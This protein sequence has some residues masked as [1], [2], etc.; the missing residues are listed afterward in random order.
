MDKRIGVIEE[1]E[2]WIELVPDE[3][4][5]EHVEAYTS[6]FEKNKM[7]LKFLY[8]KNCCRACGMGFV[9]KC[10]TVKVPFNIGEFIEGIVI[11][12]DDI[13]E[14]PS[15]YYKNRLG[16]DYICQL[17]KSG[18]FETIYK[19]LKFSKIVHYSERNIERQKSDE[20]APIWL[21]EFARENGAN[22]AYFEF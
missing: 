2:K 16:L 6:L 7:V 1:S 14:Q 15:I 17:E 5:I 12:L 22:V 9:Q 11:C 10:G 13:S 20:N 4:A 18:I 21:K 3:Y 19:P 8:V